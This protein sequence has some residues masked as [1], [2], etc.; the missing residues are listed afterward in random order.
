MLDERR[1]Q[2]F[3]PGVLTNDERSQ[4]RIGTIYFKPDEPG[5]GAIGANEEEVF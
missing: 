3:A 1:S 2:A 4:Q 5:R